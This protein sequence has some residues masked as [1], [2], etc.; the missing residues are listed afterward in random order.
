MDI[1]YVNN[2]SQVS[3]K[4][5]FNEVVTEVSNN[6]KTNTN[7]AMFGIEKFS[8][9][10]NRLI[11]GIKIVIAK[12]FDNDINTFAEM[13][14]FPVEYITAILAG[15]L[16]T[17]A[18]QTGTNA[19]MAPEGR[20]LQIGDRSDTAFNGSNCTHYHYGNDKTIIDNLHAVI[21]DKDIIIKQQQEVIALYRK[22]CGEDER[23]N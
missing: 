20:Y 21:R 10:D 22:Q 6:E 12:A 7:P 18:I 16:P 3:Y 15:T 1:H 4:G 13:A 9:N 5:K 14:G 2:S 11:D 23:V 19:D 8:M 17:P